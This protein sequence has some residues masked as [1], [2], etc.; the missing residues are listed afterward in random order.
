MERQSEREMFG[1]QRTRCGC[2]FCRAYCRI[3]PG[4]L[5]VA[6][7]E[8]LCPPGQDV[9]LWAETHLRAVIDKGYPTLVPARRADGA[10]HWFIEGRCAVHEVAPYGC[11]FFDAHQSDEEAAPRSAASVEARKADANEQGLY[12]RVWSHLKSRGLT[13]PSGDR[14]AV[15]AEMARVYRETERQQRRIAINQDHQNN[16]VSRESSI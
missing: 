14:R 7:L 10:C 15:Q 2:A 13:V 16:G 3:V 9:C 11:A 1:F 12:F 4:S 8:A 6:D 5:A